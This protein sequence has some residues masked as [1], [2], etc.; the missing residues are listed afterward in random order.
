MKVIA[1]DYGMVVITRN[2]SNP[3]KFVN[4]SELLSKCKVNAFVSVST[5]VRH[6]LIPKLLRL[7]KLIYI[8]SD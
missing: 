4:D 7:I 8:Y 5:I 2:G 6:V 1:G 3:Q